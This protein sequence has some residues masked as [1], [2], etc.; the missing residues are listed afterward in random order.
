MLRPKWRK[1]NKIRMIRACASR[2]HSKE[3]VQTGRQ[4]YL[5]EDLQMV[6]GRDLS[7]LFT[8]ANGLLAA[9]LVAKTA[10]S[11]WGFTAAL[12]ILCDGAAP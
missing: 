8:S 9:L 1:M 2:E 11:T 7:A 5:K 10:P 12:S 6:V 3:W 4:I